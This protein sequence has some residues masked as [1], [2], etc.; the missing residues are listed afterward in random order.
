MKDSQWTKFAL[1]V[2]GSVLLLTAIFSFMEGQG[3]L[4][5]RTI[6]LIFFFGTVLLYAVVGVLSS[7]RKVAD[8]Y[9]AGRDIPALYNG[10]AGAANWM[11]A[12][13][14]IGMAGTIYMLGYDGLAYI[15]GWTGGYVL[16]ALLIAPYVRKMRAYTVPDFM[17]ARY[18]GNVARG[19]SVFSA[20]AMNIVYLIPQFMGVGMIASRFLGLP[21]EWGVFVALAVILLTTFSG[22]MRGVTWVSVAQYLIAL[23]AY[24]VPLVLLSIRLTGSPIPWLSYGQALSEITAFEAANNMTS[25]IQ[26]FTNMSMLNTLGLIF[27]LMVGT[28]GLPHVLTRFYTVKSVRESRISVGWCLLFIVLIYASAPAMA[29]LVRNDIYQNLVGTPIADMPAWVESWGEQDMVTVNDVN[30]DGILAY[31]GLELHPDMIVTGAPE[32]ANMPYTV[33][34]LIGAG[35]M[36]AAVSTSLGLL[37]VLA[38]GVA[39][40]IYK[41]MINPD[42]SEGAVLFWSRAVLVVVAAL[43]ALAALSRPAL[44]VAMVAWAFSIAAASFFPAIFLG[45][46]WRRANATG[47]VAGMIVGLTV[48]ITYIIISHFYGIQ[49]FGIL[50]VNAGLFGVPANFLVTYFVSMATEAPPEDI[51]DLVTELRYPRATR[52]IGEGN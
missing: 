14:V 2:I 24:V 4:Q 33:S 36:A 1:G 12:A 15:M 21:F 46:W 6:G 51:Q 32:I 40:D 27:C 43:C 26:P 38:A 16:L 44:I 35:G 3:A 37:M 39:H 34:G 10:M 18:G 5:P 22:G 19:V 52:E 28:V 11:S 25:Y 45:I 41:K 50:P 17:A 9:V 20:V 42:A 7:A 13:S 23:T 48:T 31:E 8:Y 29:A 30:N 49:I 47:A